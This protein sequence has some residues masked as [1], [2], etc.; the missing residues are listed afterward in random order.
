M[1]SPSPGLELAIID[2]G[3]S[4]TSEGSSRFNFETNHVN[5]FLREKGTGL[6]TG[7]NSSVRLR[8]QSLPNTFQ[9]D[10]DFRKRHSR[11]RRHDRL[12]LSEAGAIPLLRRSELAVTVS[13]ECFIRTVRVELYAGMD[14]SQLNTSGTGPSN[15]NVQ[16]VRE[17]LVAQFLRMCFICV[18]L[19]CQIARSVFT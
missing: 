18:L 5:E 7:N 17:P 11:K 14:W 13:R 9:L 19:V 6:T 3:N 10:H 2:S 8:S 12:L 15:E 4:V 16:D 1:I